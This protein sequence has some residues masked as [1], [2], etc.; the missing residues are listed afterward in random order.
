[1]DDLLIR[2]MVDIGLDD[3]IKYKIA[4]KA[5]RSIHDE[6]IRVKIRL[7][8]HFITILT[9]NIKQTRNTDSSIILSIMSYAPE[10]T[11]NELSAMYSIIINVLGLVSPDEKM[12]HEEE[13][14]WNRIFKKA[15]Q[16]RNSI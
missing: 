13:S 12:T 6:N 16:D 4:S 15:I 2:Q 10:A 7:N 1:M 9:S 3:L 8:K 14:D 11:E 5:E